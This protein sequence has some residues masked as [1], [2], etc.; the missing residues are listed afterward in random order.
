[1]PT[2][3][4][5]K[6]LSGMRICPSEKNTYGKLYLLSRP[7][8]SMCCPLGIR[9]EFSLALSQVNGGDWCEGCVEFCYL[10][11]WGTVRDDK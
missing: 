8:I 2:E 10:G 1:M 4:H 3:K 9:N 7:D 6:S 5:S 11:A